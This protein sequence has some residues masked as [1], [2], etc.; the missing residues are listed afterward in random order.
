MDA[1]QDTLDLAREL[2]DAINTASPEQLPSYRDAAKNV[3]EALAALGAEFKFTFPGDAPKAAPKAEP[4]PASKATEPIKPTPKAE[5]QPAR[6]TLDAM[7]LESTFKLN[8]EEA[9]ALKAK[10][11]EYSENRKKNELAAALGFLVTRHVG[12]MLGLFKNSLNLRGFAPKGAKEVLGVIESAFVDAYEKASPMNDK[13]ANTKLDEVRASLEAAYRTLEPYLQDVRA[14]LAN[15]RRELEFAVG[16]NRYAFTAQEYS[17]A[18]TEA[19]KLRAAEVMGPRGE[20]PGDVPVVSGARRWEFEWFT[21]GTIKSYEL[22][23]IYIKLK[24]A[25]LELDNLKASAAVNA[26]KAAYDQVEASTALERNKLADQVAREVEQIL[27]GEKISNPISRQGM[28]WMGAQTKK[29]VNEQVWKVE[30]GIDRIRLGALVGRPTADFMADNWAS[31]DSER[32][33]LSVA[34]SLQGVLDDHSSR[35]RTV[36]ENTRHLKDLDNPRLFKSSKLRDLSKDDLDKMLDKAFAKAK[37]VAYATNNYATVAEANASFEKMQQAIEAAE[38]ALRGP[39]EERLGQLRVLQEMLSEKVGLGPRFKTAT[40][41][42]LDALRIQTY[43]KKP[44]AQNTSIAS[45]LGVQVGSYSGIKQVFDAYLQISQGLNDFEYIKESAK[46][47][48]TVEIGTLADEEGWNLA[49]RREALDAVQDEFKMVLDGMHLHKPKTPFGRRWM[50]W[51]DSSR[52]EPSEPKKDAAPKAT[53]PKTAPSS[54]Q[55]RLMGGKGAPW[56][57]GVDFHRSPEGFRAG[58]GSKP[59]RQHYGANPIIEEMMNAADRSGAKFVLVSRIYNATPKS[60][61]IWP[62]TLVEGEGALGSADMDLPSEDNGKLFKW[63][64]LTARRI[65]D[66]LD[67]QDPKPTV[68]MHAAPDAKDTRGPR[69]YLE[70]ALRKLGVQTVDEW[71]HLARKNGQWDEAALLA[72]YHQN[73]R[74][75][76]TWKPEPGDVVLWRRGYSGGDREVIVDEVERAKEQSVLARYEVK[77]HHI[78]KDGITYKATV[79]DSQLHPIEGNPKGEVLPKKPEPPKLKDGDKVLVYDGRQEAPTLGKV[80]KDWSNGGVLVV[81]YQSDGRSAKEPA[82]YSDTIRP[83][84]PSVPL[85]S[86][87]VQFDKPKSQVTVNGPA[88]KVALDLVVPLAKARSKRRDSRAENILFESKGGRLWVTAT[89]LAT[90]VSQSIPAKGDEWSALVAYGKT[91]DALLTRMNESPEVTIGFSPFVETDP[92]KSANKDECVIQFSFGRAMSKL[93]RNNCLMAWDAS[94]WATRTAPDSAGEVVDA[95]VMAEAMK[96]AAKALKTL[97]RSEDR[98]KYSGSFLVTATGEGYT[99]LGTDGFKIAKTQMRHAGV[100]LLNQLAVES[101]VPNVYLD[102]AW[103]KKVH[104]QTEDMPGGQRKK[105]FFSDGDTVVSTLADVEK[106]GANVMWDEVKRVAGGDPSTGWLEVERA[107]LVSALKLLSRRNDAT[108]KYRFADKHHMY[109]VMLGAVNSNLHIIAGFT[110]ER[111]S[112]VAESVPASGDGVIFAIVNKNFLLET[113]NTMKDRRVA[114]GVSYEAKG[115]NNMLWIKG[116]EGVYILLGL[117]RYSIPKDKD[118]KPLPRERLPHVYGAWAFPGINVSE[119][120][121]A[122]RVI[123]LSE[124][125][126]DISETDASYTPGKQT[127][128]PT[129]TKE[130]DDMKKGKKTTK[131][132]TK[133][134]PKADPRASEQY[135]AGVRAAEEEEARKRNT[136]QYKAGVEAAEEEQQRALKY[137]AAMEAYEK[138]MEQKRAEAVA[139]TERAKANKA[140]AKKTKPEADSRRTEQEADPRME[141]SSKDKASIAY[142]IA[143]DGMVGI[144][145]A[146]QR[147]VNAMKGAGTHVDYGYINQK[148]VIDPSALRLALDFL[149]KIG[150]VVKD[151]GYYSLTGEAVPFY[152]SREARRAAGF[153]WNAKNGFWSSP[154]TKAARAALWGW[155]LVVNE[156]QKPTPERKL[157]PTPERKAEGKPKNPNVIKVTPKGGELRITDTYPLPY[158]VRQARKAEG[159]AWDGDARCWIGPD[160]AKTRG[161]CEGW[162]LK[163]G[164]EVLARDLVGKMGGATKAEPKATPKA[165]TKPKAEPKK[166]DKGGIVETVKEAAAS[167]VD[168]VMGKPDEKTKANKPKSPKKGGSKPKPKTSRPVQMPRSWSQ[169]ECLSGEQLRRVYPAAVGKDASPNA[170]P[171]ALRQEIAAALGITPPESCSHDR[172]VTVNLT[173]EARAKLAEGGGSVSGK[174]RDVLVK[175]GIEKRC[176]KRERRCGKSKKA[177]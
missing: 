68:K 128:T 17:R 35:A 43:D 127:L 66:A 50:D 26:K 164:G 65:K 130:S 24:E 103:D 89:D 93:P 88:L 97:D 47:A 84:D 86:I 99:F 118:G 174:I 67:P 171:A 126:Q 96:R 145:D 177:A 156:A 73:G 146:A 1:K 40:L 105:V 100:G 64:E 61:V 108:N 110:N 23:G 95:E 143:V 147:A 4:K 109:G 44:V 151:G 33:R 142:A 134:A 22:Y 57:I 144:V 176:K 94:V 30:E 60:G 104:I 165:D 45:A 63:A 125:G 42:A 8:P 159:F 13:P 172:R 58:K 76:R 71:P 85:R 123:A 131:T 39:L 77:V 138:D 106:D 152:P 90:Q 18:E 32:R 111:N 122:L 150:A 87:F 148:A 70:A 81:K 154:D 25:F 36:L 136:E 5:A 121:L 11:G 158:P 107:E 140:K 54:A 82:V 10:W 149:V 173:T 28:A 15:V 55:H 46:R 69:H 113:L 116:E 7:K 59:A 27:E 101:D 62:D 12:N 79:P 168:A 133:P 52:S 53:A 114:L 120:E 137:K 98:A 20:R 34:G 169:L 56:V 3:T 163:V 49:D 41:A 124:S 51:W 75:L 92:N 29:P 170:K 78:G 160:N 31:F 91:F 38:D 37:A 175:Q 112:W 72:A 83:F 74:A 155:G 14:Q 2:Q 21:S 19:L 119:R 135:K 9:K 153:E 162:G 132:T 161:A 115:E 129:K 157:A 141:L 167:V 48:L 16:S 80:E 6:D 102:G 117:T 139:M 166:A